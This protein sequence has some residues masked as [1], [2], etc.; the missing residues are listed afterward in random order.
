VI[1]IRSYVFTY[2]RLNNCSLLQGASG[3]N[4]AD[5]KP[6]G[7][8]EAVSDAQHNGLIDEQDYFIPIGYVHSLVRVLYNVLLLQGITGPAGATGAVGAYGKPVS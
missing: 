3:A 7:P 4:G 2:S 5:G 8:G 6:G 1:Y